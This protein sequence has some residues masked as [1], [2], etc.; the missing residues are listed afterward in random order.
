MT[1]TLITAPA[2]ATSALAHF[3]AEEIGSM[4]GQFVKFTKG[5]WSSGGAPVNLND[6]YRAELLGIIRAWEKWLDR[7][8]VERVCVPLGQRLPPR[9]ELGDTEEA[10]WPL[11]LD[12]ERRD[13]WQTSSY[14]GLVRVRDGERFVFAA[15]SDGARKALGALALAGSKRRDA[16][17]VVRL[18]TSSYQH[19]TFGKVLTPRFDVVGWEA[20]AGPLDNATEAPLPEDFSYDPA[21]AI[22]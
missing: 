1:N 7:R 14:V 13:P 17:P 11:G 19:R 20:T 4:P 10:L 3:A 9:S 18:G 22:W 21:D 5:D 6:K 8:V 15:S 2:N 16:L 12:G